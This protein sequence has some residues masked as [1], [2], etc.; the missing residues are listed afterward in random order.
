MSNLIGYFYSI[1][2][3]CLSFFYD[4]F[5]NTPFPYVLALIVFTFI[6]RI[7]LL[8]AN[9]PQQKNM[10]KQFR[11]QPKMSKIQQKFG[12]D[13]QKLSEEQQK[14]YQREGFN[15]MAAGCGPMLISLP[16][17]WGVY[18]AITKPI[19]YVLHFTNEI[20]LCL[21]DS[22][23]I[24]AIAKLSTGKRASYYQ[25]LLILN[26]LK[27]SS[28]KVYAKVA[29]FFT[30][31]QMNQM[32][33]FADSFTLFGLDLTKTPSIKEPG[34]MWII[35]ILSGLTAFLTSF[36][37]TRVQKKYNPMDSSQNAMSQGC[38]MAF[39]PLF[40]VYIA[41]T[42]PAGVGFYWVISNV[43]AFIQ[44]VI[45]S[46]AYAPPKVA[47]K[48]MITDTINRFAYEKSIKGRKI[49]D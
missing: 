40:S 36:Y 4:L 18:G 47:A 10:A 16:F 5:K 46:N 43:F 44:T 9:I 6:S 41:F 34:L 38:M 33:S 17:L 11:I 13:R 32:Q 1:F 2:G 31:T 37:T 42:V 24:D 49:A 29:T 15:P 20:K 22:S 35:P 39:M 27:D 45:L 3:Y 8:P 7:V 30:P 48:N 12:N 23:I 21:A 28:D 14:L 25:E 26:H 19:S